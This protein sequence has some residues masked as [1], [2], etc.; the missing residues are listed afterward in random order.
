M[1][2]PIR[3]AE[4]LLKEEEAMQLGLAAYSGPVKRCPPGKARAPAANEKAVMSRSVEWLK[5]NRHARPISDKK[6]VRRQM[7][8]ARATLIQSP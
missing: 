2:K 1:K 6:A 4:Q 7:R 3:T 8:M 5:Q